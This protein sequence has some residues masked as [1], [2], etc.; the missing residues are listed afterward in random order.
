LNKQVATEGDMIQGVLGRYARSFQW[1][2]KAMS[3]FI[4]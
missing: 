3:P 1:L 4:G 2:H